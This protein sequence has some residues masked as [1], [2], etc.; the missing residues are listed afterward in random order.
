MSDPPPSLESLPPHA[1]EAIAGCL[2][3]QGVYALMATSRYLREEAQPA[4]KAYFTEKRVVA[5]PALA[6][7]R[8]STMGVYEE[9]ADRQSSPSLTLYLL[10]PAKLE[11]R[12]F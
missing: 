3:E 10:G 9:R 5:E 6:P 2:D 8:T 4:L 7:D 11:T 12:V 1:I